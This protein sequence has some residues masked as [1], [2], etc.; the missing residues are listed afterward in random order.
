MYFEVDN[1][2]LL[3]DRNG[4]QV[5][6]SITNFKEHKQRMVET[7]SSNV[8]AQQMDL[9]KNVPFA[10]I[11][12][13]GARSDVRMQQISNKLEDFLIR[14]NNLKIE[15]FGQFYTEDRYYRVRGE[16][17][18]VNKGKIKAEDLTK[19]W[20]RDTQIEEQFDEVS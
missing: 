17:G 10:T 9:G 4:V 8:P 2:N 3:K 1:V 14:V 19:E 15:L 11:Q 13:L 6:S 18:E 5:P 20:T 12:E 7:I 16:N